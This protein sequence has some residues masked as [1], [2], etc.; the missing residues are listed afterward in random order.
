MHFMTFYNFISL[1][2]N[3]VCSVYANTSM[4]EVVLFLLIYNF[5]AIPASLSRLYSTFPFC[6]GTTLIEIA[7]YTLSI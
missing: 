4:N 5:L 2:W 6:S 3:N 7:V 1:F